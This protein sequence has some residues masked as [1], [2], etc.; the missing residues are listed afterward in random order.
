MTF[1]ASMLLPG[2]TG[3]V[4]RLK[5]T[6]THMHAHTHTCTHKSTCRHTFPVLS[7]WSELNIHSHSLHLYLYVHLYVCSCMHCT[8]ATPNLY[9]RCTYRGLKRRAIILRRRGGENGPTDRTAKWCL[10]STPRTWH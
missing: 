3:E 2:V 6:H 1:R 9:V 8:S 5:V 7:Y 10:V 4:V